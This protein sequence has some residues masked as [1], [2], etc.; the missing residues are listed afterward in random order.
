MRHR[1]MPAGTRTAPVRRGVAQQHTVA[2]RRSPERVSVLA[3][4][5]S[6]PSNSL[7]AAQSGAHGRAVPMISASN[8]TLAGTAGIL[9]GRDASASARS[10]TSA[11]VPSTA[12]PTSGITGKPRAEDNATASTALPSCSATSVMLSATT[13][14]K[15]SATSS[16]TIYKLRS[17]L[18]ALTTASTTSGPP[19]SR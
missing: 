16:D 11:A 4:S 7:H 3:S 15:P 8:D 18:A 2:S 13:T 12:V 6:S 5:P 17:T 10:S 14:G 9:A 19:E 1:S